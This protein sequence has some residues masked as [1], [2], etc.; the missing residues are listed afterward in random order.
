LTAIKFGLDPDVSKNFDV[1]YI[2]RWTERISPDVADFWQK[3]KQAVQFKP[4]EDR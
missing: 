2:D 3:L 1:T 4:S